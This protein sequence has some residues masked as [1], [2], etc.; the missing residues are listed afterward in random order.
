M[1]R[2]LSFF[3]PGREGVD[4]GLVPQA[5]NIAQSRRDAGCR[6]LLAPARVLPVVLSVLRR[7]FLVVL[8]LSG[9]A[10]RLTRRL[11]APELFAC[12]CQLGERCTHLGRDG[13]DYRF[14]GCIV[15]HAPSAIMRQ[16]RPG[17][18]HEVAA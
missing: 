8:Q 14:H 13:D 3:A 1:K 11:R 4:T 18:T 7:G 9:A 12:A 10:W 15:A 6:R 5:L 17:L 2:V 16:P